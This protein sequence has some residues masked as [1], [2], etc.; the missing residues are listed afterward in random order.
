ML[1]GPCGQQSVLAW[2]SCGTWGWQMVMGPRAESGQRH[3]VGVGWGDVSRGLEQELCWGEL[4]GPG[5]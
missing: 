5:L 1:L 3:G 2:L 4:G